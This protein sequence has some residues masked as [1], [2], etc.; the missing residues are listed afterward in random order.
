MDRSN[1]ARNDKRTMFP[2]G[3]AIHRPGTC[4]DCPNPTCLSI[5]SELDAEAWQQLR[6]QMNRLRYETGDV[7][8]REQTPIFGVY[9]V[10]SGQVKL[11][12]RGNKHRLILKIVG[13]SGALGEEDMF[14]DVYSATAEAL[15]PTQVMFLPRER[16]LAFMKANPNLLLK[17]AARLSQQVKGFQSKV[18]EA[19]YEEVEARM[20]RILLA[21]TAR[22]GVQNGDGTELQLK[23]SRADLAELAGISTETAIRTL[24]EFADRC[25][26]DLHR[27]QIVVRDRSRLEAL[28]EPFMSE[29]EETLY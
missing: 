7:L 29:M 22:Y 23:L 8:Y 13:P 25:L 19:A 17:L 24:R 2:A 26:I 11:T 4:P 15:E 9:I 18:M 21:L 28:V 6:G 5:F 10:C 14:N 27:R 20:A 1:V 3:Q 16:F 12:Q